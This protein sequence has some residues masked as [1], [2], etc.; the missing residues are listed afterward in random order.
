MG[1]KVADI[2]VSTVEQNEARQ[3]EAMSAI[4]VD[5]IFMDKA[6]GKDTNRPQLKM[7]L[8][9]IREGDTVYVT[10]LS[11]LGRSTAD[12][13]NLINQMRDKGVAFQSLKEKIDTDTASGKLQLTML[14]A[15]SEFERDM[16]RERQAE[17]IAVAKKAGKYK[18]RKA[19]ELAEIEDVKRKREMGVPVAVLA[20]QY[21]ISRTTLYKLLKANEKPHL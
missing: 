10:E 21:K 5:K 20:R 19:V 17:G 12:L 11:R 6:S 16:I 3:M 15:I 8:D 7:M 4:G 13:L 9:Y 18:G 2:R 1:A 14:A